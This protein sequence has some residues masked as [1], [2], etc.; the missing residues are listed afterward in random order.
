MISL[1]TLR[2]PGTQSVD[3]AGLELKRSSASASHICVCEKYCWV[4]EVA[5]WVKDFSNIKD[6]SI[7]I[8]VVMRSQ[9]W[10]HPAF[11]K[12]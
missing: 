6:F 1:C 7:R 8:P 3:Q 12:G 4:L 2:C 5:Q 9:V 11:G 10:L